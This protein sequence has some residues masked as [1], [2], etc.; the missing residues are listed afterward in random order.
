MKN[1][2]FI[3]L[4]TDHEADPENMD[5]DDLAHHLRVEV[6]I[7]SIKNYFIMCYMND[8]IFY[9]LITYHI[10]ASFC[11]HRINYRIF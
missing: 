11:Q 6:D 9:L 8:R 2:L 3:S 10:K 7:A 1:L 5:L 4:I